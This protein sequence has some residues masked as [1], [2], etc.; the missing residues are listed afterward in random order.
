MFDELLATPESQHWQWDLALQMRKAVEHVYATDPDEVQ[1]VEAMVRAASGRAAV[2]LPGSPGTKVEVESAFLHGPRSQVEFEVGGEHH[3][4]ELADL[5]VLGSLAQDEKLVG[6]RVCFIQAKRASKAGAQS[7]SR[8]G[9]DPWQ[10]A[11]LRAF[12]EFTGVSGVFEAQ[13]LHLR[14]RTGMLGAYGL[15]SEPGEFSIV[16][17]RIVDSVLGG[18]RSVAAKEFIPAFLAPAPNWRVQNPTVFSRY[19]WPFLD[20]ERCQLCADILRHL[21]RPAWLHS[22][23]HHSHSVKAGVKAREDSHV[24][25]PTVLSCIGMDTFV[26]AWTALRLGELWRPGTAVQSDM[27]LGACI[28]AVVSRAKGQLS[29]L[30][31]LLA[32]AHVGSPSKRDSESRPE[33]RGN[34]GGLAILSAIARTSRTIPE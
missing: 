13:S 32:E 24:W 28:L 21:W 9:I 10:L 18:R 27:R 20:P 33:V 3:Q 26:E 2:A 22:H 12:P 30:N 34:S 4:C 19:P 17:A 15:L 7:P 23:S 1:S 6:Q 16:S 5:L 8:Y 14:N 31:G 25:D 29:G 11:L